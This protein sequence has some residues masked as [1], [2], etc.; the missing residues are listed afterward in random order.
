ML[1]RVLK[2]IYLSYKPDKLHYIIYTTALKIGIKMQ[3][4][5]TQEYRL[6]LKKVLPERSAIE[7]DQNGDKDNGTEVIEK[8]S[9]DETIAAVAS[10]GE[11]DKNEETSTAKRPVISNE[12]TVKTTK[13]LANNKRKSTKKASTTID[14]VPGNCTESEN[15][16]QP[17]KRKAKQKG[18]Q[19]K[20]E[21]K[22]NARVGQI[23]SRLVIKFFK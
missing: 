10:L 21:I 13:D 22:K 20:Y 19:C 18:Y 1:T 2:Y 5:G 12:V 7:K 4:S 9:I 16:E 23:L 14:M 6:T 11:I 8:S 15:T 3:A 17:K